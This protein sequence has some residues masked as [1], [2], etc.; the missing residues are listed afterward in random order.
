MENKIGPDWAWE[1]RIAQRVLVGV[2]LA[3]AIVGLVN[4]SGAHA[5][6]YV[7][8]VLI[9]LVASIAAEVGEQLV[10]AFRRKRAATRQPVG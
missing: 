3:V 9:L 6:A 4:I 1:L 10:L 8:W 5:D 7:R 2:L